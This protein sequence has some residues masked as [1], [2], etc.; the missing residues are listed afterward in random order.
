M[1]RKICCTNTY[2]L[3]C[4]HLGG[5][6][7]RDHQSLSNYRTSI[8]SPAPALIQKG[9]KRPQR[10]TTCTNWK[11][12][13]KP[14]RVISHG[15]K[16]GLWMRLDRCAKP[17]PQPSPFGYTQNIGPAPLLALCPQSQ[18]GNSLSRNRVIIKKNKTRHEKRQVLSNFAT[19]HIMFILQ[20]ML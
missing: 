4:M 5:Q 18:I 1:N 2:P 16:P 15:E 17:K 8:A 12:D 3:V 10:T 20:I 14:T 7:A 9:S 19:W 13:F 11:L 6:N